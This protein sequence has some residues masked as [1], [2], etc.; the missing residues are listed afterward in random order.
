MSDT[1][2]SMH[3]LVTRLFPICRSITGN[4][5]RE[6]L[7][8]LSEYIPLVIHEVPTGYRAFDWTVPKEWNIK[9]AYIEDATGERVLDFA[10]NNLHVVGYSVPVDTVVTLAELQ[11][12]LYSLEDQPDAIPYVTSYYQERWGFCMT[13]R[14]RQSLQEGNYRVVIDSELKDGSLTYAECIVPGELSKEVLISTYVC[15]PSMANNELS[16]PAVATFL[17]SWVAS[18]PRRYTYRFV[19][20]PETIGSLVYLSKNLGTLREKIIAGFNLT[21]IGDERQY[22]F[23]PSR[24]GRTFADRVA[25]KVLAALHPEFVTYSF[26]ERGSDERQYCSPGADLPVVSI[27]RSKYGTYPEYHTSLDNLALVTPG[28]LAGSLE[29]MQRCIEEIERSRLY[30]A[31]WV[32]EPQLGKRGLYPTLSRK[33]HPGYS[34]QRLLDVLTYADGTHSVADIAE[35][36]GVAESELE[37]TLHTLVD[38]GLLVED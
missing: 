7:R 8:I 37:P 23:M 9:G 34:A 35:L 15:H 24:L 20:V 31:A 28:G 21:C 38:A 6:T 5:V 25:K 17:A 1:G 19:F 12:H 36:L 33:N 2:I 30:R 22:S 32:G 3:A 10:E 4:G 13:H 29:V 11:E 18:A 16:G 27:M 14:Q 26:L